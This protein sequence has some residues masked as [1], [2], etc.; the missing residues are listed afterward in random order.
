MTKSRCKAT[1]QYINSAYNGTMHQIYYNLR[2]A[3]ELNPATYLKKSCH[4]RVTSRGEDY[5]Q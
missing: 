4:T 5:R 2:T 1:R 3:L